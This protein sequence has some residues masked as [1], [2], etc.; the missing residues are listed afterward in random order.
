MKK[1]SFILPILLLL[2]VQFNYAQKKETTNF[3][4]ID[5]KE[6]K[7]I[8]VDELM[9]DGLIERKKDD[10]HL[11]LQSERTLLNNKV[12]KEEFHEKYGNLAEK[13]N[14]ERGSY[15]VIYITRKCTAVGDFLE[16]SFSGRVEGTFSL[17]DLT[18]SIR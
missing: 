4:D 13:F 15:R 7:K 10:I 3:R 16:D 14:I 12:L 11:S 2:C 6:L 8:F 17:N 9:A 18:V 5:L 1:A